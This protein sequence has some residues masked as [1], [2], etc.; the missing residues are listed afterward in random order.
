MKPD[1]HGWLPVSELKDHSEPI[2][3]ARPKGRGKWSVGIAY[4]TVSQKWSPEM[5]SQLAPHGFT[6]FMRLPHPPEESQ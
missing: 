3:Y 4:W 1:K 5:E 2:V 6:H